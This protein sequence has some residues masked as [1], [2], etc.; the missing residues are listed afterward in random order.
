MQNIPHLKQIY[1]H[2]SRSCCVSCCRLNAAIA[3]VDAADCYDSIVDAIA[4]LIF[5]SFGYPVEAV[6]SML[7]AIQEMKYFLPTAFGDSKGYA[8]STLEMKYQGLCQGNGAAPAGWA[9]VSITILNAHNRC[10]H[11]ATFCCPISKTVKKLSAILFVDD[12]DLLH[13]AMQ[14]IEHVS[15][16]HARMQESILNWGHLLIASGGSYKPPKCFYHLL[17]F[18]WKTGLD[19]FCAR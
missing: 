11:T 7:G 1:S 16:T 12:C 6:E 15:T 17:S 9:V 14:E 2:F 3:S 19:H 8:N 10:G 18:G 13:I 5:Q 4:S